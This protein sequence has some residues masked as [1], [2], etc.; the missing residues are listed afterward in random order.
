MTKL[1]TK[2]KARNPWRPK[3][4]KGDAVP[5]NVRISSTAHEVLKRRAK[6]KGVS[7]SALVRAALDEWVLAAEL[8]RP[9]S[10]RGT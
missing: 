8:G 6:T 7:V 3:V 5:L 2:P 10:S 1:K 4:I 9:I